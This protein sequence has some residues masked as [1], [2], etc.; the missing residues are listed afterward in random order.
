MCSF[1]D[2]LIGIKKVVQQMEK[3]D[4]I[5]NGMVRFE[6]EDC[7]SFYPQVYIK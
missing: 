5:A 2:K 6:R 3:V 4:R 7:D 1:S